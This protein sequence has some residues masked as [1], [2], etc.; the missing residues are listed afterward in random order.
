MRLSKL[1]TKAP[2]DW[3]VGSMWNCQK[4]RRSDAGC[5]VSRVSVHLNAPYSN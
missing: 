2:D 5:D 3:D 4:R 1:M